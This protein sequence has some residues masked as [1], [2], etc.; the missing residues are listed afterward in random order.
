MKVQWNLICAQFVFK[1]ADNL[2]QEL[3]SSVHN[4]DENTY[5][6]SFTIPIVH[7]LQLSGV[8]YTSI[9]SKYKNFT[10]NKR[11]NFHQNTKSYSLNYTTGTSIQLN[12]T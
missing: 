9:F 12:F 6:Y 2:S 4:R 1:G 8:L 3:K 11:M 7:L 5:F 10:Q